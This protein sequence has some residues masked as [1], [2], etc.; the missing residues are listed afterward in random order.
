MNP[1]SPRNLLVGDRVALR[2]W[3]L[4]A[5]AQPW[6]GWGIR[7]GGQRPCVSP[8]SVCGAQTNTKFCCKKHMIME[9][10]STLHNENI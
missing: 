7:L 5:S 6:E 3:W 10:Q 9:Y 8:R 4:A 2:S 1:L